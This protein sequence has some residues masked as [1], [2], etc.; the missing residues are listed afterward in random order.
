MTGATATDNVEWPTVA[1][2]AVIYGSWLALTWWHAAIPVW[3]L[4]P[5]GAWM[6][7]WQSSLQHEALHGHPT[8]QRWLNDAIGFPPLALWLPYVRYRATHLR[9]HDN[10]LLTDPLDDP[11]SRYVL[12]EQWSRLGPLDRAL[13]EAQATMA[14]RLLIGPF[15]AVGTFLIGEANA[16]LAGDRALARIWLWHGV[17]VTGLLVWIAGVCGMSIWLYVLGFALPG[18]ALML[19]RSFCEH[20]ADSEV[21]RRTAVVEGAGPLA[22]LFLNNSLHA[23]HHERPQIAWYRLP[24][25]WRANRER[26]LAANGGLLYRGYGDIFRR[27]LLSPHDQVPHPLGRPP[28]RP[29]ERVSRQHAAGPARAH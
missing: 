10:E 4:V 20:R 16:I 11:E 5:L 2:A 9:H 26:L 21:E 17:A 3:L 6:V 14:G 12:P 23:A 13:L 24:A 18:T 15:W 22:L 28:R 29:H 27:Y 8:R 7:C 25:Y 1:L 19:I